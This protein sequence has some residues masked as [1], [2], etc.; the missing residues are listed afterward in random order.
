MSKRFQ[1]NKRMQNPMQETKTLFECRKNI[2]LKATLEYTIHGREGAL[3]FQKY[4]S[5]SS[6]SKPKTHKK[7]K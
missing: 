7:S 5:F 1:A 3:F 4:T 6:K 2:T